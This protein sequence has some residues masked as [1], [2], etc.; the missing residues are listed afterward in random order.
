MLQPLVG[1]KQLNDRVDPDYVNTMLAAELTEMTFQEREKVYEELHGVDEGTYETEDM[2]ATT[3]TA[4]ELALQQLPNRAV[5]DEAKR[6][7]TRYVEDRSFRLMFLRSEYYNAERA[8]SRL[9]TFLEQKVKFFGEDAL[10]RPVYL[11][12]LNKDDIAVLKSG[13]LQLIPERDQSGRVILS[14]FNRG[15]RSVEQPKDS[16]NYVRIP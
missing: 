10:A 1:G 11:S 13:I 6:V 3:L 7:N 9:V 5:Y 14:D 12:D 16:N 15:P 4:M 8:A 2:L